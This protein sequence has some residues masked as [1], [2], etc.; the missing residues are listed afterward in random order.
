M[1]I[2]AKLFTEHPESVDET[3]FEHMRFAGTFGFSLIIAAA[4]A[5]IHAILPFMFEKTASKAVARLYE[6]THTR[7]KPT[8][9][10]SAVSRTA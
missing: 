7:G 2:F 1:T 4:A 5:F 6:R 9:N 10:E 3:Y 8:P